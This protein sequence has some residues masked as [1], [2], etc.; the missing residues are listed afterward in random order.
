M[1]W[2]LRPTLA[3]AWP[4]SWVWFLTVLAGS[5]AVSLAIRA[6]RDR[7]HNRTTAL[8]Q[9]PRGLALTTHR[10]TFVFD[11][12]ARKVW[13]ERDGVAPAHIAL[14]SIRGVQVR[15]GY[16]D[17][18]VEEMLLE[19]FGLSDFHRDYRDHRMSWSVV[20]NTQHGP[21]TV[22]ALSQYKKRDLFDVVTEGMHAVLRS[23]GLYQRGEAVA[24][25]IEG[26]TIA[27][28]RS[29]GLNIRGG[30]EH[31]AARGALEGSPLPCEADLEM[32]QRQRPPAA[33]APIEIPQA[34]SAGAGPGWPS[35]SGR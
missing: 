24:S 32:A 7:V 30:Y 14:D 23:M 29:M 17:A 33:V 19:G 27:G 13:L 1:T 34:P 35:A 22:A 26:E 11:Q 8:V 5:F 20:M 16:R 10:A 28:L 12:A 9:T 2:T 3:Y 25:R 31:L 4:V 6:V 18:G 21:V 15:V